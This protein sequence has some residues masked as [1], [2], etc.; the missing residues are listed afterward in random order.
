[1]SGKINKKCRHCK[2]PLLWIEGLRSIHGHPIPERGRYSCRNCNIF[3]KDE[4]SRTVKEG[5]SM[6]EEYKD[7]DV[8]GNKMLSLHPML[9]LGILRELQK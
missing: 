2:E 9:Q 4:E 6:A 7:E 5:R 3:H 1:M 8:L